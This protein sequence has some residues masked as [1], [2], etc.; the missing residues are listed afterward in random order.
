ME[1]SAYRPHP[2][3]LVVDDDLRRSRLT[4]FFR[5]LLA[6]PHFIWLLLWAIVAS[7]VWIVAWIVTLISGRLP[8]GLHRF[9]ERYLRYATHVTAYGNLLSNPYPPFHGDRGYAIDLDVAPPERQNRLKTL[10]RLILVIPAAVLAALLNQVMGLIAFATWFIALFMGRMPKGLRDF[11]A[12]CLRFQQQTWGYAMFLTDRYPS[13]S[14][15]PADQPT[16]NLPEP[17]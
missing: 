7:L 1:A 14:Q 3:E 10:F 15:R 6:I 16:E 13:L 4:V 17:T 2:I 9:L 12:Y 5:W 11:A 8:G